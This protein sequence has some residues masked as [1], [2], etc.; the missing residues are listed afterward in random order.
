MTRPVV[1]TERCIGCGVC[2]YQ[3]PLEG[4]AAIRVERPSAVVRGAVDAG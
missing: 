1:H 2:E 4:V 3:C